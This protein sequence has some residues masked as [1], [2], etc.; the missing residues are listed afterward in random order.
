MLI[1]SYWLT[2]LSKCL[3]LSVAFQDSLILKNDPDGKEEK[4]PLQM[5]MQLLQKIGSYKTTLQGSWTIKSSGWVGGKI[6]PLSRGI[7]S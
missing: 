4:Q 1:A 3:H 5:V 6:I 2:T 7:D